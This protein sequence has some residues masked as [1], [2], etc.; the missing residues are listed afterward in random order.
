M[1]SNTNKAPKLT[2]KERNQQINK[3][4]FI[5]MVL[6]ALF[7][8]WWYVTGYGLGGGDPSTYTYVMGLPM[9][10]FL[11][12]VLGYVLFVVATIFV[13]KAFFKDFDL[14]GEDYE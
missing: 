6:Y 3:E 2:E 11:S 10:F 14:G 13:V 8:I 12:S 4:A 9:W 1:D 7:F 5:S